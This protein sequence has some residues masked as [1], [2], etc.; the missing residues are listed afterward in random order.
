MALRIVIDDCRSY[1]RNLAVTFVDFKKAFDSVSRNA[2]PFCLRLHGVPDILISAVMVLYTDTSACIRTNDGLTSPFNT[3]SGVLQGDTLAPLLFV[4][5]LDAVL[6]DANLEQGAYQIRRRRSSRYPELCLP[7][8]AF[9]D[10][11]AIFSRDNNAAQSS[12][13]RLVTSAAKVGLNISA[14]KT[15]VLQIGLPKIPLTM[16]DDTLIECVDDFI[17]LG[18]KSRSAKDVLLHRKT[19]AWVAARKLSSIFH[20]PAKNDSKVRLFNAAVVPV[21]AYGLEAMP[22]TLSI[23]TSLDAAHRAL[24]RFSL[25]IHYPEVITNASLLEL[26]ITSLAATIR[27][28]RRAVIRKAGPESGLFLVMNNAPTELRRRGMGRLRTLRD[29][30][31]EI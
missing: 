20:S 3:T 29:C 7:F 13:E 16:P 24:C 6:R 26:G 17:Y 1:Q 28:R 4:L 14:S 10:D 22:Q 27:E 31:L 21:L 18:S 9:A 11:L 23:S 8:L 15:K 12:L 5:I 19:L 2:I 30:I 25:G